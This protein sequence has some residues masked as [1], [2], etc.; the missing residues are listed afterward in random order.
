MAN[1]I[2]RPV[3]SNCENILWGQ[4]IDINRDSDLLEWKDHIIKSSG[5][6]DKI[7]PNVCPYCKEP[8]RAFIISNKFPINDTDLLDVNNMIEKWKG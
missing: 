6:F 1:I 4:T 7:T 5:Y 8:I 3:C 2:F